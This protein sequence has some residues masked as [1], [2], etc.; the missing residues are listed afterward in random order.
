MPLPIPIMLKEFPNQSNPKPIF[1]FPIN[2]PKPHLPQPLQSSKTKQ[3]K[4]KSHKTLSSR[5][6]LPLSHTHSL[7]Q[8]V[9]YLLLSIFLIFP[10]LPTCI[11]SHWA[12]QQ[13]SSMPMESSS[14]RN[15]PPHHP[16][17]HYRH[18][19]HHQSYRRR[20]CPI[21]MKMRCCPPRNPTR[22]HRVGIL[23]SSFISSQYSL[24]SASL[25]FTSSPT[26]L[27]KMVLKSIFLLLLKI[28]FL[29]YNNNNF[30]FFCWVSD[31]AQFNGF[32]TLSKPSG[33]MHLAFF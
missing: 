30:I 26:T 14:S 11:G 12:H 29:S 25:S 16:P 27:L 23:K 4:K 18:H 21:M 9:S 28:I 8:W 31:L 22:R 5:S 6:S 10:F 7:T 2:L 3:N 20:N 24:S 17:R 13:P 33:T 19:Y 32:K 15:L 1:Y